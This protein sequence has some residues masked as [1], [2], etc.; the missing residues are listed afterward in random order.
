MS[1][2]D[3]FNDL[4]E[5]ISVRIRSC[6]DEH[7]GSD[8]KESKL[9]GDYDIWL[10]LAGEARIDT[11]EGDYL[12]QAGD[13]VFFYPNLSY[14]ASTGSEGCRFIFIH[15]DFSVGNQSKILNDYGLAG[16]VPGSLI[17]E[18]GRQFRLAYDAFKTRSSMSALALKG[19]LLTL[20]ARI[21][22]IYGEG[23]FAGKFQHSQP[24]G[25]TT[26]MA[27]LQP[28]FNYIHDH[29]Y[30]SVRIQQL[31]EVAGMSEKYFISFFKNALGITPGQ[32]VYHLKMNKA[33]DLLCKRKYS[34]KQIA[35]QLGYPDAYSFS[36]AFKKFYHTPPSKFI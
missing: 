29:L 4:S 11:Y 33:R 3:I 25:Y 32:Y 31:A 16:I 36:K 19:S 17:A 14:T 26:S 15:F 6:F 13:A 12:A 2:L 28:V 8:W 34:I 9:H 21:I 20:L 5:Q 7:H 1:K 10:M 30:K 27:A 24:A 23:N 35:D 22:S 18:E